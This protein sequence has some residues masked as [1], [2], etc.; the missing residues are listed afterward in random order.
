MIEC[1]EGEELAVQTHRRVFNARAT[2]QQ[3][4]SRQCCLLSIPA[5]VQSI[6]AAPC[7]AGHRRST[8][9]CR[10]ISRGQHSRQA[11]ENTG[12][13]SSAIG[14]AEF[15]SR[16]ASRFAPSG[17]PPGPHRRRTAALAAAA[18]GCGRARGRSALLMARCGWATAQR[19]E[20]ALRLGWQLLGAAGRLGR[21]FGH[22]LAPAPASLAF[23]FR[24][25]AHC[26][27]HASFP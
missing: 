5:R 18:S 21:S 17:G 4:G 12:P 23:H 15:W 7:I 27:T 19:H 14:D 13:R 26:F 3:P 16:F 20:S 25:L 24:H 1:A 9:V 2:R 10:Q 6:R 11:P 8:P 22:P